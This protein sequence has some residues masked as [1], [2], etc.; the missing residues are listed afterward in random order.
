MSNLKLTYFGVP[1]ESGQKVLATVTEDCNTEMYEFIVTEDNDY[2]ESLLQLDLIENDIADLRYKGFFVR[3][4]FNLYPDSFEIVPEGESKISIHDLEDISLD[5]IVN[6]DVI[7]VK[8]GNF[9]TEFTVSSEY[10]EEVDDKV[11]YIHSPVIGITF[12]FTSTGNDAFLGARSTV[13]VNIAGFDCFDC[14]VNT[15]HIS[16]YYMVLDKIWN[17]AFPEHYGMLCIKCLEKRLGRA[18]KPSDFTDAIVNTDWTHS[19][20]LASRLGK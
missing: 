16:E 15:A 6:G 4:G 20:L 11:A 9:L 14:K 7:V 10:V 13:E 17:D 5:E 1:V 2:K 19:E 12:D 18:L 8:S 3:E